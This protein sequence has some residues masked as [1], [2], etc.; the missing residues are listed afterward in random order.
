VTIRDDQWRAQ[1][2]V[3][4][5]HA[6]EVGPGAASRER[7]NGQPADGSPMA[8]DIEAHPAGTRAVAQ[9]Q[10]LALV[11]TERAAHMLGGLGALLDWGHTTAAPA[12]LYRAVI[13]HTSRVSWLLDAPTTEARVHRAW[14]AWLASTGDD[15][16]TVGRDRLG[17]GAMAGAPERFERLVGETI[18]DVLGVEPDIGTSRTRSAHYRIGEEQFG[19]H[20]DAAANFIDNY[21]P[22]DGAVAYRVFSTLAHPTTSG[23]F[24]FVDHEEDGSADIGEPITHVISAVLASLQCWRFAAQRC[25]EYL[26]WTAANFPE[27]EATVDTLTRMPRPTAT[28]PN[29]AN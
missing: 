29:R 20:T 1:L 7:G 22:R 21:F 18:P 27:W 12:P 4:C 11:W 2:A 25:L 15:V 9:V 5:A 6:V 16:V 3:A 14:V 17:Q 26:G 10:S 19:T 24:A 23:A 13:E 8:A 28:E